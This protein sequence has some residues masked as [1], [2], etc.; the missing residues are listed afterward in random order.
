M[1]KKKLSELMDESIEM[2]VV[3][4]DRCLCE[5]NFYTSARS[6]KAEQLTMT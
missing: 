4:D 6:R 2:T 3:T 1:N 5:S